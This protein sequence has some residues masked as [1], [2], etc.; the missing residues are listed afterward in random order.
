MR[1]NAYKANLER[2]AEGYQEARDCEF[3]TQLI[4]FILDTREEYGVITEDD[5]QGFI[6]SFDFPEEFEYCAMEFESEL[7]TMADMKYEQMKDER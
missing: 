1:T 4:D 3:D 2:I 6:D 5:I 7:D